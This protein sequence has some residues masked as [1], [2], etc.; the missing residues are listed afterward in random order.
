MAYGFADHEKFIIPRLYM[1]LQTDL[2]PTAGDTGSQLPNINLILSCFP[3]LLTS[4][5]VG[6]SLQQIPTHAHN[7]PSSQDFPSGERVL[8]H[9]RL[10]P[11]HLYRAYGINVHS[12]L[13]V[14]ISFLEHITSIEYSVSLSAILL[15]MMPEFMRF[16]S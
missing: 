9:L 11:R 7:Y 10:S 5:L 12:S 4:V 8:F 16:C 2:V 1:R 15:D 6:P 3:F 14:N 13:H